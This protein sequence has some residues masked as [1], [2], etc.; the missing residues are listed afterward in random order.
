MITK[1]IVYKKFNAKGTIMAIGNAVE[2]GSIIVVFDESGK[3]I[4]TIPNGSGSNDGL[5]GYTSNTVNVR[6]GSTIITFND[7]GRQ[8]STTSV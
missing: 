5:K 2:R 8:I 1:R 4:F 7:K 3:Q 6:R